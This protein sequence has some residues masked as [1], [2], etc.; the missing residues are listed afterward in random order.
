MNH[1]P[2][3]TKVDRDASGDWVYMCMFS[4]VELVSLEE[5]DMSAI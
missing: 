1:M 2:I 4:C 5:I 3:V